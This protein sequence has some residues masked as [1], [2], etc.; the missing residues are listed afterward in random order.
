M[1]EEHIERGRTRIR[2]IANKYGADMVVGI[3]LS[4]ARDYGVPED[5]RAILERLGKMT[6][7]NF[8]GTCKACFELVARRRIGLTRVVTPGT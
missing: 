5:E 1:N 3:T 6:D 2:Y 8:E 4:F 7:A